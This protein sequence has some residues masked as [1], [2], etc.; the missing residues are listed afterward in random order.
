MKNI[1]TC[2]L[3]LFSITTFAQNATDSVAGGDRGYIVKVGDMAPGITLEYTD[4]SSTPLSSFKGKI[5]LLQFTASWCSVC[6]VEMPHLEKEIWQVYKNKGLVFAG[7]D[8]KEPVETVTKFA[9]TMKISYPL[10]LDTA[11]TKFYSFA[12]ESAGVTRNILI[13]KEGKIAYLTRLYDK[14][15]FNTLKKKIKELMS[16]EQ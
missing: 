16:T 12:A 1:Y 6:R 13:D 15:E 2:F 5:V 11:G 9:K 14:K 7:I 8:L 4:G 3:V 10:T